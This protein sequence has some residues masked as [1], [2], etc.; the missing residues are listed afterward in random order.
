MKWFMVYYRYRWARLLKQQSSIGLSFANQE[1]QTSVFRFRLQQ[2]NVSLPFPFSVCRKNT[3]VAIF[4]EFLFPFAE[5]RKRGEIHRHGDMV[6]WWHGDM[7]ME[8]RSQ[9]DTDT[10][11][12]GDMYSWTHGDM[13]HGDMET[14][15]HRDMETRRHRA[16]SKGE[17]F[18]QNF[19]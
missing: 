5:C 17:I 1:K 15:R 8:T 7:E 19:Y 6:T 14:W 16:Y 9:G 3:E 10:W 12:H 13:K 2:T 4:R 11:R 18:T